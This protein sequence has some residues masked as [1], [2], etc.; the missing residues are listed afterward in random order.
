LTL[1]AKTAKA[2]MLKISENNPRLVVALGT[3]ATQ[4]VEGLGPDIPL[5]YSMVLEPVTF[6]KRP[7]TGVVLKVGIKEQFERIHKLFPQRKRL[8]VIYNPAVSAGEI[9]QA[10]NLMSAYDLSIYAL[11]VD[12]AG[13]VGD[14][15]QRLTRDQVDL[16]WMVID[17]SLAQA[18]TLEAL[19][20]HSLKEEIPLLGFSVYQ[21]KAGALAAFCPDYADIGSQT[22]QLAQR[23][24]EKG[25]AQPFET[26]RKV[27]IYVNQFMLKQLHLEVLPASPEIRYIE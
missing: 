6:A 7:A 11:P 24:L 10:R 26:P 18:G 3:E 13:G 8:G 16:I 15:L 25:N 21:V 4:A 17:E 23:L 1:E 12:N 14:A 9:S 22:A 19:V 2:Q 20:K 5:V 27:V